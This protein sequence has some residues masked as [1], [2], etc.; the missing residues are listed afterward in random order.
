MVT[1]AV[2]AAFTDCIA[3]AQHLNATNETTIQIAAQGATGKIEL[4][5]FKAT[6]GSE[7]LLLKTYTEN[8]VVDASAEVSASDGTSYYESIHDPAN[9]LSDQGTFSLAVSDTGTSISAG[10]P[11]H[12]DGNGWVN[13]HGTLNAVLPADP[14]AGASGTV[15]VLVSF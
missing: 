9:A 3:S 6:L 2:E 15:T 7:P 5:A 4:V 1:G 13:I 11:A 14:A 10:D 8:T 12:S